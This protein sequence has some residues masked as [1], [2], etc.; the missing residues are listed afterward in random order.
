MSLPE[1][2]PDGMTGPSCLAI[3]AIALLCWALLGGITALIWWL[4][5]L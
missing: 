1:T 4:I 3:V 5:T 2:D